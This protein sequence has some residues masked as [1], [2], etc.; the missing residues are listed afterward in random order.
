M[1]FLSEAHDHLALRVDTVDLKN[2]LRDVETDCRD[3]LH[4]LLLRIVGALT[5]PT[6]MALVPVEEPST[7]SKADIRGGNGTTVSCQET[8]GNESP[9]FSIP[10]KLRSSLRQ[11]IGWS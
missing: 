1:R 8:E 9:R 6:S 4:G 2:R 7:A 5:A 10:V 11:L 3:R